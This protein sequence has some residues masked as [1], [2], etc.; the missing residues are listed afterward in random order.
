LYKFGVKEHK[1]KEKELSG[2]H[3]NSSWGQDAHCLSQSPAV[4]GDGA[5]TSG[6]GKGKAKEN[7][8]GYRE[9]RPKPGGEGE[10]PEKGSPGRVRRSHEEGGHRLVAWSSIHRGILSGSDVWRAEKRGENW[11][12]VIGV[13][14]RVPG[15]ATAT[16]GKGLRK[17]E[18]RG[19]PL[20]G[21]GKKRAPP[22]L[23]GKVKGEAEVISGVVWTLSDPLDLPQ[24]LG[25]PC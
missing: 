20:K 3:P 12:R 17:Q 22:V 9:N 10:A 15:R 19:P 4:R 14:R 6:G 1:E 8:T 16:G 2:L 25:G 23:A 13:V 5:L 11:A 18:I 21:V 24:G 7:S